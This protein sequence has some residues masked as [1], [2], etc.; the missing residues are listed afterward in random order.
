[1]TTI[2]LTGELVINT[3]NKQIANI[4]K[5]HLQNNLTIDLANINK[6]DTAGIAMLIDLQEQSHKAS[7]SVDYINIPTHV[8]SLCTLYQIKL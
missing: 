2:Q 8:S 5:T 4:A 7:S 6:I 3:I 1:M